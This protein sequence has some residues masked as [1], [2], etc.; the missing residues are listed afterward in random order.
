MA[1]GINRLFSKISAKIALSG[2]SRPGRPE[3]RQIITERT[4]HIPNYC[5]DVIKKRQD[6]ESEIKVT[7]R[8][9][10]HDPRGIRGGKVEI[11]ISNILSKNIIFN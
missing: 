3:R 9:G 1:A 8:I 10:V 5:K 11:N 4:A 6:L 7:L 2:G